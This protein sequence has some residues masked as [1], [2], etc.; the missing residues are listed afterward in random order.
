M[1]STKQRVVINKGN[2]RINFRGVGPKLRG[3]G[4]WIFFIFIRYMYSQIHSWEWLYHVTLVLALLR[5]PW[6]RDRAGI[7]SGKGSKVEVPHLLRKTSP[8]LR[9]AVG[10]A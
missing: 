4:E 3:I 7:H 10:V 9:Q 5:S 8:F 6:Q 1:L 2:Y